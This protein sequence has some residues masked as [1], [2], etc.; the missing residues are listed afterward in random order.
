[1]RALLWL[2]IGAAAADYTCD[3]SPAALEQIVARASATLGGDYVVAHGV[4]N[5]S[6]GDISNPDGGYGAAVFNDS[7]KFPGGGDGAFCACLR[8]D[9]PF[10]DAADAAVCGSPLETPSAS[11]AQEDACAQSYVLGARDAVVLVGCAPPSAGYFSTQT[12]VYARWHVSELDGGVDDDDGGSRPPQLWFPE[13][14]LSE[15]LNQLTLNS[16]AGAAPAAPFG[17][18]VL[19]VTTADARTHADASAAFVGAGLAASAL[20]PLPDCDSRVPASL[21][22]V[23]VTPGKR[24]ALVCHHARTSGGG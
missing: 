19:V 21:P 20:G 5:W 10:G 16:T 18:T 22:P 11:G 8:G 7:A 14:S 13:A 23:S 12:N 3:V 4:W 2:V 9:G 1:M 24:T 15:A 6:I 17:A